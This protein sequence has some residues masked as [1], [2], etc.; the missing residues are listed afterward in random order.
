MS[1]NEDEDPEID[2]PSDILSITPAEGG[3][4]KIQSGSFL[5]GMI[6]TWGDTDPDF[7]ITVHQ[8][9]QAIALAAGTTY[10]DEQ[11]TGEKLYVYCGITPEQ[12][13]EVSDALEH[14]AQAAFQTQ[15]ST[16]A[17]P[18]TRSL[19]DRLMGRGSA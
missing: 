2:I 11:E 15:A 10:P 3:T 14:A 8:D 5:G 13:L 7:G 9:G 6:D 16:D 17:E 12:A 4:A 18:D 1:A 19:L